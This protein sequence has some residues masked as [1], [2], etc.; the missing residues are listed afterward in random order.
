MA[1][2]YYEH[3]T[4]YFLTGGLMAIGYSRALRQLVSSILLAACGGVLEL[5]QLSIPGRT[6]SVG[7][8]GM[9]TLGAWLGIVIVFAIRRVRVRTPAFSSFE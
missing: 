3:F 5:V 8:F 6:A 7:D 4:A 2:N 9:D 1:N